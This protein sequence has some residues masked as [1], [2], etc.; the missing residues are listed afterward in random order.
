[1]IFLL[2]SDKPSFAAGSRPWNDVLA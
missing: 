2:Y 1:V